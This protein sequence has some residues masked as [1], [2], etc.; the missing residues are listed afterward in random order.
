M[1]ESTLRLVAVYPE[2]LGTYGDGGNIL[3]LEQRLRWR[4]LGCDV[5][6]VSLTDPIPRSGDLYVLGGGEDDAQVA[7]SMP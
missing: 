4:G 7:P 6:R 3:V 1:S 2:L 5:T